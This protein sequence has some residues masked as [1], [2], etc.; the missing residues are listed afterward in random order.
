MSILTRSVMAQE[1]PERKYADHKLFH[2]WY[3]KEETLNEVYNPESGVI[4]I[5]GVSLTRKVF[6]P[7][8]SRATDPTALMKAIH[9]S[10]QSIVEAVF[11]EFRQDFFLIN[12]ALYMR[13]FDTAAKLLQNLETKMFSVEE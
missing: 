10:K 5:I 7:D 2:H 13:D 9:R 8:T 12:D 4:H 3:K 6:V 1:T 11:G